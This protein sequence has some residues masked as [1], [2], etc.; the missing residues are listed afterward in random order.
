MKLYTVGFTK[1]NAK[2]FFELLIKNNVKRLI[3]IRLN[4]KSQ[5]AGFAKGED[6]SYFLKRIG[7]IEYI[8]KPD[9]APTKELLNLYR[10]KAIDWKEYEKQYIQ[11][12]KEREILKNI[13]WSLFDGACLLCSEETADMCHR[14]LLAEYLAG[15]N[16]EIEITH[17]KG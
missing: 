8:Y 1:K 5:L 9:Y 2:Q 14:R 7:N 6:L 15:A 10:D 17:L 12:L 4:N 3:D 13:E 11:I 16:K